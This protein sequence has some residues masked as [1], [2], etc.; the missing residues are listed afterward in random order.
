MSRLFKECRVCPPSITA[1]ISAPKSSTISNASGDRARRNKNKAKCSLKN[2][3]KFFLGKNSNPIH[4]NLMERSKIWWIT[5]LRSIDITQPI[6]KIN[7]QAI[8]IEN[9]HYF[10]LEEGWVFAEP[11]RQH[12][13]RSKFIGWLNRLRLARI[14]NNWAIVQRR[15]IG[16][17]G[18]VLI[19]DQNPM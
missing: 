3:S 15:W 17:R 6:I 10:P 14:A 13:K 9:P 4:V 11:T 7:R 2:V 12:R 16:P 8:A 1:S 5:S 18:K 19:G